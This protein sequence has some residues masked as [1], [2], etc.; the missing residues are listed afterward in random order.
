MM[1]K[2]GNPLPNS[3][4]PAFLSQLEGIRVVV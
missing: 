2:F 3:L 1:M 4:S